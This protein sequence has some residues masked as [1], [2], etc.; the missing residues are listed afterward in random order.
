MIEFS[1]RVRNFRAVG[2][3][4]F[5]PVMLHSTRAPEYA[6]T[7]YA[8]AASPHALLLAATWWPLGLVLAIAYSVFLSRRY[9]GKVSVKRDNS[10]FY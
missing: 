10:G 4:A 5:F 6:L 7:A 8:V 1:N 9:A 2:G 3:A